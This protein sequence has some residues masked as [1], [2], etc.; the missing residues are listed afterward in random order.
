MIGRATLYEKVLSRFLE[1]LLGM[2]EVKPLLSNDHF[3]VDGALLQTWASHDSLKPVNG[4]PG[5]GF[6]TTDGDSGGREK[7]RASRDFHEMGFSNRTHR[8]SS[9]PDARL[10]RRSKAHPVF[11][12]YRGHLLI[13]NRHHLVVDSW[14]TLA[15]GY[16]ER[17]AAQ[18]MVAA[19]RGS[20]PGSWLPTRAILRSG[21]IRIVGDMEVRPRWASPRNTLLGLMRAL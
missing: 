1:T 7:R 2:E 15:D 3:S 11:L 21:E 13:D 20:T 17:N 14:M 5:Q 16:G 18:Q 9:D 4:Q 12:S 8:S 10:A 6:G 19:L